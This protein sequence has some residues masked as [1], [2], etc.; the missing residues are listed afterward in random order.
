[1]K[2]KTVIGCLAMLVGL[3]AMAT[4][5]FG[6]VGFETAYGNGVH[7]YF[8]HEYQKAYD[9]LSLALAENGQDARAYYFRGLAAERIGL[10]NNGDFEM[11]AR[12]EA[13]QGGRL[14]MVNHSLERIQG[15]SRISIEDMRRE[16]IMTA[17][18]ST[19]SQPAVGRTFPVQKSGGVVE[20]PGI[21]KQPAPVDTVVVPGQEVRPAN[22]IV[23][24][25]SEPEVVREGPARGAEF[26]SS[27]EATPFA[28]EA[29]AVDADSP[30]GS[31]AEMEKSS[32]V[33]DVTDGVDLFGDD[34]AEPKKTIE[35]AASPF[36]DEKVV[37]PMDDS[38]P[39]GSSEPAKDSSPFGDSEPAADS[40]SPFGDSSAA[41]PFGEK[42]TDSEPADT[43]SPFGDQPSEPVQEPV[44]PGEGAPDDPFKI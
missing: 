41:S 13:A 24:S 37:E 40:T 7:Y 17:K 22:N 35:G 11:G 34:M 4:Q 5:S 26:E 8:N 14:S 19:I 6:Q 27:R 16:A 9:S 2:K 39:F 23:P 20:V 43:T 15:S 10:G 12:V 18:R 38:S 33:K 42:T 31:G 29:T 30:F 36:G 28:K 32:D 21:I 3:G 1:M 44:E 25:P